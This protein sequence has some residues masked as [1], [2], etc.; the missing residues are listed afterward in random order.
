MQILETKLNS[1]KDDCIAESMDVKTF[2][3]VV[4]EDNDMA[5]IS[6]VSLSQKRKPLYHEVLFTV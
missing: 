4:Y 1:T 2:I 6:Y 5:P 3:T